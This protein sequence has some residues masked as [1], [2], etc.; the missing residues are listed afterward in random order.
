M[1]TRDPSRRSRYWRMSVG[2]YGA[3]VRLFERHRVGVLYAGVSDP[4][5]PGKYLTFRLPG[6]SRTEALAWAQEQSA[7]LLRGEAIRRPGQMPAAGHAP[8]WA[9]LIASYVAARTPL[10]TPRVQV[11]DSQRAEYWARVLGPT[12]HPMRLSPETW[13]R[14]QRERLSGAVDC[15]GKP[16]KDEDRVIVRPRVPQAEAQWLRTVC[17]WALD[18]W[19]DPKGEHILVRSPLSGLDIPVDGEPRR[20]AV[21][22]ERWK[23]VRAVADQVMMEDRTEHEPLARRSYLPEILDLMHLTGHRIGAILQLRW[24]DIQFDVEGAPHGAIRWPITTDKAKHEHTVPAT[25][26]IRAVI[27]RVRRERPGLGPTYLFPKPTNRHAPISKERVRTWLLRA[28]RLAKVPKMD[29]SLF[30]AYRRGWA[31]ARKHLSLKDVAA[32]GGWKQVDTLLRHYITTDAET[33][34][35][36]LDE[37]LERQA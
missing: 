33:M 35:H 5:R 37:P 29:G 15:R 25:Q 6:F 11:A 31:T 9:N 19:K 20:P 2:P 12:A 32:A 24:Q 23:A 10:K 34:L 30:H 22:P 3:R 1:S 4:D 7:R 21:T 18:N 28:E 16:V 13:I 36:V 17:R 14:I 27:D 8:T 26:A